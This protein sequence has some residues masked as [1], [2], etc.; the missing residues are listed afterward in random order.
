MKMKWEKCL[1]F[2]EPFWFSGIYK[3]VQYRG[4][5]RSPK[6]VYYQAYQLCDSGSWGDYV[7]RFKQQ[8]KYPTFAQCRAMCEAHAKG[9][10][11][12]PARLKQAMRAQ[13][14][15]LDTKGAAA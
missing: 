14:H 2:D 9:N 5:L 4:S 1:R 11:A 3:I 10:P 12:T 8:D 15:W 13:S 7:E 6:P